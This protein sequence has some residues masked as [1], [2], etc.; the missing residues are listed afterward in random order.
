M[1]QCLQEINGE[2]AFPRPDYQSVQPMWHLTSPDVLN[3]FMVPNDAL[4]VKCEEF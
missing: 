1:S 4:I 2:P 3:V